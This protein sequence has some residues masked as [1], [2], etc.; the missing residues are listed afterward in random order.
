M[1][2]F[3]SVCFAD[4]TLSKIAKKIVDWS[5]K[6]YF[7]EIVRMDEHSSCIPITTSFRLS[8]IKMTAHFL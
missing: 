3:F 4:R 6:R 7:N 2:F 1:K 5:E 8:L